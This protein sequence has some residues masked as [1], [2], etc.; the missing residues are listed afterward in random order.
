MTLGAVV[1]GLGYME[2]TAESAFMAA[3]LIV[4]G[5]FASAAIPGL[6]SISISPA[7]AFRKVV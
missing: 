7:L 2:V 6:Q 1:G 4:I 5:S 3:A